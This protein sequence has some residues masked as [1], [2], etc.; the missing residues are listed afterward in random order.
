MDEKLS[1]GYRFLYLSSKK[2]PKVIR[3]RIRM[4][5]L[6]NPDALTNAVR[7]TEKRYPYFC[8]ELTEKQDGLY[9][10][11]NERPL[12]I[13]NSRDGVALNNAESNY[14]MLAFSWYDNWIT[15]DIFHGLT[16]GA[17][18]YEIVRTMLYYYCSERYNVKLS[19]EGIRLCDDTLSIEEFED[20]VSGLELPESEKTE[21]RRALNLITEGN[22]ENDCKPT[23]YSVAIPEKEFMRFNIEHDGSPAT[24]TALFFSRAV[25]KL[26]PDC[27]DP[28][29]ISVCV[30]QRSVLDAPLAHQ[31]LVGSV[32]LEYK[33]KMR[34]WSI[35]K[36][37]TAYRGMVFAQTTDE[38]ILNGIANQRKTA[39]AFISAGNESD[40]RKLAESISNE[41][42][43]NQTATVSYVGKANYKEA[44]VYIRDFRTWTS[45][46]VPVLIEI[47]A[48]N[49]RFTL[50]F[51]QNFSS[52]IYVDAFLSE[53]DE[54]NILFDLQEVSELNLPVVDFKT[55]EEK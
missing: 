21:R 45:G 25:A 34:S 29:R 51:I 22:L 11:H 26:C 2:H 6:I 1:T 35:L 19:D 27:T 48:V 24:M 7:M 36:Q 37:A 38:K 23:V 4:R 28:V 18:A 30:N 14:H 54:N 47:S 49:G 40:R 53:L 33:E 9:F 32:M 15:M 42:K 43:F 50:D 31:S 20:P 12:V 5:D 8:V 44:E 39:E 55:E 46:E 41:M 52:S 13:S 17:G 16:D 10:V 3:L